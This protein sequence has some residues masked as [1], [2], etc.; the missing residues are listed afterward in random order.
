MA[1]YLNG[2]GLSHLMTKLK[3]WAADTFAPLSHTHDYTKTR[4]KGNAE[5]SYRTGDVN[6]TP[7]NIGA[8]YSVNESLNPFA[9]EISYRI[10]LDRLDNAFYF[11]D[12]RWSVTGVKTDANNVDTSLTAAQVSYLFDSSESNQSNVPAGGKLVVT[13]DFTG[14][15]GTGVYTN[16][17]YGRLYLD[18]YYSSGPDSVAV[19][20]YGK[21]TGSTSYWQNLSVVADSRNKSTQIRYIADQTVMYNM[22]KLEITVNAK[23]DT[24]ATLSEIAYYLTRASKGHDMPYVSKLRAETLYENLTAPKFIG[25]LEGNAA[26]ATKATK[27]IDSGN[28]TGGITARWSGNWVST[29]DLKGVAVYSGN[30]TEI[31]PMQAATAWTALGGG[32]IGKKASLAASDIP[33]HASTATTYG[34]ASTSNYGHAK[35]SSATDSS[36]EA[37]AATPKAVKAAYDKASD[38]LAGVAELTSTVTSDY[39]FKVTYSI[40]NGTTTC[41][42][43]VYSAGAEVTSTFADSCFQW[44]YDIG[45][46]WVSLGTGKTKAVT[47]LS[48]FGGNVKC[49]FTPP[50]S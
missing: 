20:V 11:A 9:P 44:Y 46:G 3:T 34:A 19:R 49:D 7:H 37:L 6:L 10:Q 42:A 1:K 17:P 30:G 14:A 29:S 40:S 16:Y 48:D 45:S 23:S 47:T 21:H 28:S 24:A 25:A 36:S 8:A 39:Y 32:A 13:I 18:F 35:L 4:V 15:S 33:A 27:L 2:D 50:E 41:A 38:A 5:S 12:K 22:Q 43:H 26:T 31:A